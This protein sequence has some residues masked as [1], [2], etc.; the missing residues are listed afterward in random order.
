MA[1]SC[2]TPL[3]PFSSQSSCEDGV[4]AGAGQRPSKNPL[5]WTCVGVASPNIDSHRIEAKLAKFRTRWSFAIAVIL[6]HVGQGL[7]STVE[8]CKKMWG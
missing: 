2:P 7:H 5:M 6:G 1:A 3:S 8:C 4:V